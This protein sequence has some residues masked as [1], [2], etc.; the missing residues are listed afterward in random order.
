MFNDG[1]KTLNEE[2]MNK[3][4]EDITGDVILFF[5]AG[6][7]TTSAVLAATVHMLQKN[8]EVAK[9]LLTEIGSG[10]N[11]FSSSNMKSWRYMDAV[12]NEILRLYG[13]LNWIF[14]RQLLD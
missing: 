4:L 11:G 6:T 13:P 12:M 5:F 3:A 8:P 9:K 10:E 2:E 7:D 1:L 14:V